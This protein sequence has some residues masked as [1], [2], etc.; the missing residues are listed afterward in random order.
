MKKTSLLIFIIFLSFFL[1]ACNSFTETGKGLGEVRLNIQTYNAGKDQVT[2]PSVIAFDSPWNGYKYWMAYTPYP[3]A[4]GE[5]ENP[6]I[7]VSND[8]LYWDTPTGMVNPIADNE[9][10]GCSELKDAHILY[11]D[12][13]DRIEVWYLGRL[14]EKLGGDNTSLLLFRKHSYDGVNWSDFEIMSKTEYLSPSIVWIN[15]K[16]HFWGIGYAGFGNTGTLVH[17]ESMDG[18]TWENQEV[19]SIEG[20]FDDLPIWHGSV[21]NSDGIFYFTYIESSNDSQKIY[22][23]SSKDG[24]NFSNNIILVQNSFYSNWKML[25]RPF[26]L[27]E[28]GTY[29]LFYGVVTENREWYITKSNGSNLLNLTGLNLTDQQKMKPLSTSVTN[30]HAPKYILKNLLDQIK[31]ALRIELY[32]T[33]PFTYLIH[34]Y[35]TKKRT[36]NLTLI[37]LY[38]LFNLGYTL[39]LLKPNVMKLVL[40]YSF[41][42]MMQGIIMYLFVDKLCSTK[43]YKPTKNRQSCTNFIQ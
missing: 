16:Y 12:D 19:C 34:K 3:F 13:I 4:N 23:C 8:L 15:N 25:Y 41:V 40:I 39:L 5:E 38:V 30:T 14:S 21:T 11:R 18:K 42:S 9:E 33:L 24:I 22:C 35:L 29:E 27:I 43:I 2:H 28:E 7:A 6:S 20:I 10:T 17:Y 32:F 1:S 36:K 26:L 37:G 31:T